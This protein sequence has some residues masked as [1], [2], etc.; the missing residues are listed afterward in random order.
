MSHTPYTD[1]SIAELE[2]EIDQYEETIPHEQLPPRYDALVAFR[3][4]RICP[5]CIGEPCS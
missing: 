2:A 5:N 4:A 1:R 3:N